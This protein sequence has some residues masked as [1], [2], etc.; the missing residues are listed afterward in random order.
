MFSIKTSKTESSN[1]SII[2]TSRDWNSTRKGRCVCFMSNGIF[3]PISQTL[4][5]FTFIGEPEIVKLH[6]VP[7]SGCMW[8]KCAEH[9][10][11]WL[12][13]TL[14]NGNEQVFFLVGLIVA[15]FCNDKP[16]VLRW[17]CVNLYSRK[18]SFWSVASSKHKL[19]KR[20]SVNIH[21]DRDKNVWDT[22]LCLFGF[23]PYWVNQ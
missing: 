18:N 22:R 21:R 20:F 11:Y 13:W 12:H 15:C 8:P 3:S 5:D 10:F 9:I 4:V 23:S 19:L 14:S 16:A 17:W 1:N 7:T 2:A 6:F